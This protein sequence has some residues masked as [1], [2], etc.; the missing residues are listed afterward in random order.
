MI[1][2][3]EWE[4]K[5]N[6]SAYRDHLDVVKYLHEKRHANVEAKDYNYRTPLILASNN[7]KYAEKILFNSIGNKFAVAIGYNPAMNSL[8]SIDKSNFL[9]SNLLNSDN[10]NGYYLFNIFPDVSVSKIKKNNV[11]AKH[12]FRKN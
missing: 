3:Y 4:Y 1:H 9:I 6:K 7:G 12:I 11:I 10:Y 8:T 2:L 5:W